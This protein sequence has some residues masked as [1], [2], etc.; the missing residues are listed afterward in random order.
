MAMKPWKGIKLKG[1]WDA[2][3]NFIAEHILFAVVRGCSCVSDH[4]DVPFK[5]IDG[6][7]ACDKVVWSVNCFMIC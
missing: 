1:R 5:R 3:E 7:F 2:L 6:M 4:P